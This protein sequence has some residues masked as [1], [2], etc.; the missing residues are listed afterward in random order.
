MRKLREEA[1]KHHEEEI[2]HHQVSGRE[3]ERE[4]ERERPI[5]LLYLIFLSFSNGCLHCL[6]ATPTLQATPPYAGSHPR[7]E[8]PDQAAQDEDQATPEEA[9]R[10]Q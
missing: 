6:K 2:E 4:R 5:L 7:S 9:V 3:R 8:G 10:L 1:E